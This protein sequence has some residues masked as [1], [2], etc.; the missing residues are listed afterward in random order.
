MNIL[1]GPRTGGRVFSLAL[2]G[3][4]V[5]LNLLCPLPVQADPAPAVSP[6]TPGKTVPVA[7]VYGIIRSVKDGKPL[8]DVSVTIMNKKS[9]LRVSEK[10]NILGGYLFTPLPEGVYLI[11]VG[12]GKFSQASKEGFLKGGTVGSVDFSV[13]PLSSGMS[14]VFGSVY[15][16]QGKARQPVSVGILIK[17]KKTGEV[18]KLHSD[19][20]G[21]YDLEGIPSGRYLLQVVSRDFMPVTLT[22][23]VTG[24][25]RRD[26][27]LHLN[28]LARAEIRAEGDR[29]IQ[30]T[31]GAI[32]VVDKKK[33][34]Q[35]LTAGANYTLMQNTPGIEYFSRSGSQGLSNSG[36]YL[37][38]RGYAAAGSNATVF[39]LSSGIEVSVDGVP[40]NNEA[41]GGEILDLGIMNTDIKSAEIQRGVTTSRQTGNYA[42]GCAIN[43]NL[44]EPAK[45]SYQAINTGG[46]S[47][48]LYYA[49][50]VNNTGISKNTN[51]GAYSDF[52]IV[53]QD[54]FRE[55]TPLTEYQYYGNLTK[56]LNSGKL[57]L[58]LTGNFMDYDRGASEPLSSF[59]AFGSSYNGG[60]S[61]TANPTGDPSLNSPHSPFYH[62]IEVNN[63]MIDAG[64]KDQLTP[65]VKVKNSLYA[66]VTPSGGTT[67]PEGFVNGYNSSSPYQTIG[68]NYNNQYGYQFMATFNKGNGFKLGDIAEV[69]YKLWRNDK[70][71]VGMKGQYATYHYF[72]DPLLSA[73]NPIGG[74]INAVYSQTTIAAYIEDHYR[75]VKQILLNVGFRVMSVAQ[76]FDDLVPVAQQSNY[77]LPQV[78]VSN[79]GG[80]VLPLPHVGLN[81]YPTDNWKFYANGGESFA[82]PVMFDY[83]GSTSPMGS[84]TPETV[85]DFGVGTRYTTHRGFLSLDAFSDWISNQPVPIT[86]TSVAGSS[87]IIYQ[88]IAAARQQGIE[89][90][91]KIDLGYGFSGT[92]NY[93]YLAG[94]LG[95]TPVGGVTNF[96]GD[97]TPFVPQSM[98]NLALSYDHGP[99]HMTVDERYTGLM[100]VIDFTGGPSG[101]ANAQETVPAYFTTDLYASY[102]L[103]VLKG[104]YK[105]ASLYV[106]AYNLLNTNYYNPAGLAPGFNNL[107]TLFIYPG[108]PVNA[109]AGIKVTF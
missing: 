64:F 44:V 29:E 102:D 41:D 19:S 1:A 71:Y 90:E 28:T 61:Y 35:N 37:S 87:Y 66:L 99:Y 75:P 50:Y 12:G 106:D 78:G 70:L 74:N 56:Y 20:K 39:G 109:F 5:I 54:G 91:G 94:V 11:L 10:S 40:L 9:G 13:T 79:G 92:A 77:P 7:T 68:P 14:D 21:F 6:D 86:Y 72:L 63:F 45:D 67:Q 34:Q 85:W 15:R 47:Y 84:I 83:Q 81:Y 17:N 58:L 100:N 49:S 76:Y 36:Y 55:F 97:M 60:P 43:Y 53:H 89:A 107:E 4:V 27:V 59:E 18:Y 62:N 24:K 3:L 23:E 38:C 96:Q 108:E 51:I 26:I 95:N 2:G 16:A 88:N 31:T 98:G 82:A 73:D 69:Q 33:F 104:W 105:A 65:S 93:T 48:G 80:S 22:F 52:S 25:T 8:S 32:S 30:D 101:K 42:A 103:P 57:Y 46:G